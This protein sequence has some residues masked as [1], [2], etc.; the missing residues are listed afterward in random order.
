ML[1]KSLWGCGLVLAGT[2]AG[3]ALAVDLNA[4]ENALRAL[5]PM[6]EQWDRDTAARRDREAAEA[7]RAAEIE[8]QQQQQQE[9][10]AKQAE[11]ARLAQ[12]QAELRALLPPPQWADRLAFHRSLLTPTTTVP[13]ER[14]LGL[15][16]PAFSPDG[17]HA[18][19]LDAQG[20]LVL[21]NLAS[22]VE[23]P[24][25]AQIPRVG[26]Y[27]TLSLSFAGN[28]TLL[29]TQNGDAAE[30]MDLQGQRLQYWA[31]F[32]FVDMNDI[33]VHGHQTSDDYKMRCTFL[34][35][36]DTQGKQ[37]YRIDLS[38]QP[39]ASCSSSFSQGLSTQGP[40]EALTVD[41]HNDEVVY[42]QNDQPVSR[43]RDRAN[44]PYAYRLLG[45]GYAA[46]S[47]YSDDYKRVKYEL[48]DLRQGRK[49]CE[50]PERD[51]DNRHLGYLSVGDQVYSDLPSA[52]INLPSCEATPVPG[53][54]LM[55][56]N[57]KQLVL[58]QQHTGQITLLDPH[59]LQ[60]I[61][62]LT[63]PEVAQAPAETQFMWIPSASPDVLL[64]YYMQYTNNQSESGLHAYDLR[65]GTHLLSLPGAIS[66]APNNGPIHM[67]SPVAPTP[68]NEEARPQ[69]ITAWSLQDIGGSS[70]ASLQNLSQALV[71]DKYESTADYRK[72]LSAL[73]MP[74]SMQ[75]EVLDYDADLAQFSTRWQGMP[76]ALPMPPAQARRLD[77]QPYITLNGQLQVLDENFLTLT[78]ATANAPD[79]TRIPIADKPL[80]DAVA[81]SPK[82][83]GG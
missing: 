30:L 58:L 68:Y 36:Y 4:V 80:H 71:K 69:T 54:R 7:Y 75:V 17:K 61:A 16:K 23:R 50:L 51:R 11:A 1:R 2:L 24:L 59:T 65:K 15:S 43:F 47:N 49:L 76:M 3:P 57:P 9:I 73:S 74:F 19:Y 53:G 29:V 25:R 10:Q 67:L 56:G 55:G 22:G 66:L 13:S 48:W 42:Y 37:R 20:A 34:A 8:R 33:I 52:R 46:V 41:T 28:D 39:I 26:Q 79:G 78:Q 35:R 40:D 64:L 83:R 81:P 60:A 27:T 82:K 5:Q 31:G 44:S 62:S 63:A 6:A 21:R 70:P 77:G 45:G 72:R 38:H 14:F 32:A 18:A 12:Q